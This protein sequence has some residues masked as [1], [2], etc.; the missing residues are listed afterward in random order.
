M[1]YFNSWFRR[2]IELPNNNTSTESSPPVTTKPP[3]TASDAHALTAKYKPTHDL[4]HMM[5]C[6]NEIKDCAMAGG[7]NI[8]FLGHTFKEA[9]GVEYFEARGFTVTFE[10]GCMSPNLYRVHWSP[11]TKENTL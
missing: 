8:V 10:Q 3:F 4:L 5:H 6:E 1:N 9:G 7:N 2:G 11:Q